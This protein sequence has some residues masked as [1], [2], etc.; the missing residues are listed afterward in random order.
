MYINSRHIRIAKF[1]LNLN[2]FDFNILSK[3]FNISISTINAYLRDIE[4]TLT[5]RNSLKST[6]DIINLIK[7]EPKVLTILKNNQHINKTEKIDFMT[8]VFLY[9]KSV[10]LT[11][12]SNFLEISRR[13]LNNYLS[14]INSIL[15]LEDLYLK[16]NSNLGL[17]LEGNL[18]N[19]KYLLF[20]YIYKFLIEKD[21]LP[22]E[23]RDILAYIL[24]E[25]NFK[26]LK[27]LF[28][29]LNS[30]NDYFIYK[31]YS[32]FIAYYFSYYYLDGKPITSIDDFYNELK[33]F[34]RSNIDLQKQN[35]NIFIKV[36]EKSIGENSIVTEIDCNRILKWLWYNYL[37][38]VFK[39]EDIG[40]F[41]AVIKIIPQNVI[42][43]VF[44]VKQEFEN[45]SFY[46]GINIYFILKNSSFIKP[47]EKYRDIFVYESISECMVISAKEKLENIY[48]FNFKKIVNIQELKD[49]LKYNKIGCIVTVE[50]L[51]L[52]NY[53]EKH[54][55]IPITNLI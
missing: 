37:K 35:Y 17:I 55:H 41:V 23:I 36:I 31:D 39:I 21:E 49:Y 44:N 50:N 20:G 32:I 33:I 10:N 15:N 48:S 12:V 26:K 27:K 6:D 24:K 25:I 34:I 40:R 29:N 47:K 8:F 46:E 30:S 28:I 1:I 11:D 18:D 7:N 19:R 2:E 14:E 53:N 3:I 13:S 5:E 54:I 43:F 16:T 52:Q 45:F 4:Y 38:S 42:E 9:K 51:N 22:K